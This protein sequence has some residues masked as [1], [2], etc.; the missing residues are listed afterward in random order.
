MTKKFNQFLG[1]AGHLHMMAEFL[2]KGWNVAIPEVDIGD[3]IFV[4]KDEEGTLRKVQV[5][6][7]RGKAT[8]KGYTAQFSASDLNLANIGPVVGHYVFIVRLDDDTWSKPVIIKQDVLNQMYEDGEVG[9]L[10]GKT[11]VFSFKYTQNGDKVICLKK[12]LSVFIN[13]YVDFPQLV[14]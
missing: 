12:D 9:S 13:D 1:K 10:A 3:D 5:K 4:V 8:K 6:T 7:S 2:M 11:I 14:H